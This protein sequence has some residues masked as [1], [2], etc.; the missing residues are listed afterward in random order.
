MQLASPVISTDNGE[1]LIA[2]Q[3]TWA[4]ISI[5]NI[6]APLLSNGLLFTKNNVLKRYRAD[7]FRN[8]KDADRYVIHSA[9]LWL[10]AKFNN[11]VNA[12]VHSGGVLSFVPGPVNT[13]TMLPDTNMQIKYNR[14]WAVDRSDIID[15]RNKFDSGLVSNGTFAVTNSILNWPAMGDTSK[16]EPHYIA[17]FV[18]A[19]NDKIYN[20]LNG[21][22]PLIKGDYALFTVFNGSSNHIQ[23]WSPMKAEVHL[24]LYGYTCNRINTD[25]PGYVLNNTIFAQYK[26]I[27]RGTHDYK[28]F[29]LGIHVD[30]E[31][32][33]LTDDFVGCNP[34]KR[35]AFAYNQN[36]IDE[37]P[38]GMGENPPAIGTVM[39]APA[40]IDANPI[41][42]FTSFMMYNN[43][44]SATGNP[45]NVDHFYNYMNA[46]WLDDEPLWYNK[47][48]G[49]T[50]AHIFPF[51]DDL[52]GRPHWS[53][54]ES[55]PA[56]NDRRFVFASGETTLKPGDTATTTIGFVYSQA[57]S[58]GR[59]ASL[60]KL[61]ED[62]TALQAMF[63]KDS[64]PSCYDLMIGLNKAEANRTAKLVVYPNPAS[65][66][67]NVSIEDGICTSYSVEIIDAMGKIVLR[68]LLSDDALINISPIPRGIYFIR[69][70][71]DEKVYHAK[72]LKN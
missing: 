69:I 40:K 4:E 30:P 24:M 41:S 57:Q 13:Q 37:G 52:Q 25:L 68:E 32:G 72:F 34:K 61:R 48:V 5:N 1:E 54:E 20:P 50:A 19:D 46:R 7:H 8:K 56:P 39:L 17:P 11:D 64:F 23:G 43:D 33:N 10:G 21:D 38:N 22:Y 67:L 26:I 12:A 29:M 2:T 14:V 9:G 66:A 58:G 27:N 53:M 16:G 42:S 28:N 31:I 63:D 3:N 70:V 44:F 47:M 60:D 62:I 36:D 71:K 51:N 59:L 18:D 55:N 65:N 6:Q 15:F 35:Y 49:D 45:R